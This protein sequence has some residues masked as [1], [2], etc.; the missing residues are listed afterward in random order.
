MRAAF[1]LAYLWGCPVAEV[2]QRI[3]AD[4]FGLWRTWMAEHGL[5]PELRPALVAQL[6]A[7]TLNG[8]LQRKDKQLFKGTD[9]LPLPWPEPAKAPKPATRKELASKLKAMFGKR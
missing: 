9:I 8:P 1:S 7:A 5:T 6:I 4:E 2:G 3:T